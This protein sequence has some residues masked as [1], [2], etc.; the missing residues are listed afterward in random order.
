MPIGTPAEQ[1]ARAQ[2]RRER[3]AEQVLSAWPALAPDPSNPRLPRLREQPREDW[4]D[5]VWLARVTVPVDVT[6]ASMAL[7]DDRQLAIDNLPRP[8]IVQPGRW[9]G[10]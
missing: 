2:R 4:W 5:R 7:A 9:T 6:G 3:L 10:A 8:L 1:A